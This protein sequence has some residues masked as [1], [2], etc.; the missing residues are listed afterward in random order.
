M[1]EQNLSE[2]E[3]AQGERETTEGV[4]AVINEGRRAEKS[5]AMINK[6]VRI[7]RMKGGT[8]RCFHF[9]PCAYTSGYG[10]N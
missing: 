8:R 10:Q 1:I 2:T 9:K 7:K 3:M 4:G 5:R 6:E